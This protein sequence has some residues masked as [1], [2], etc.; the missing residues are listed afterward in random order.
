MNV[1]IFL[2]QVL[3]IYASRHI[4]NTCTKTSIIYI[5]SIEI[6]DHVTMLLSAC[7]F[8]LEHVDFQLNVNIIKCE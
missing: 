8:C 5:W 1:L 2:V 3:Y 6:V 4:Y 7:D